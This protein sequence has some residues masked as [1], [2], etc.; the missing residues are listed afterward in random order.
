MASTLY[1]AAGPQ[2]ATALT[3]NGQLIAGAL[4]LQA[5]SEWMAKS[6]S[7]WNTQYNKFLNQIGKT[8]GT[9]YFPAYLKQHTSLDPT[10]RVIVKAST[11]TVRYHWQT[12]TNAQNL[13][14]PIFVPASGDP[15]LRWD[16]VAWLDNPSN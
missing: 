5:R 9:S 15:G 14:N 1:V 12:W 11:S 3:F 10:S 6:S 13:P 16:V 2:A 4:Y 8:G 7:W